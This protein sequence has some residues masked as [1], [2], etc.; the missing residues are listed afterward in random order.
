MAGAMPLSIDLKAQARSVGFDLVGIAPAGTA[1]T[2]APLSEWLERGF[3][4]ER[5]YIER[6][7]EA[8]ERPRHVLPAV[9]SVVILRMNY[10]TAAP[11]AELPPGTGRVSRYAWGEGDYHDLIRDRLRR[12]AD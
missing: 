2:F 7:R 12:L 8:Y 4:G 3:A 1:E 6:R 5:A 10:R 11:P 9:K